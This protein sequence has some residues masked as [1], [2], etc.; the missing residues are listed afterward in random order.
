M[1]ENQQK[2]ENGGSGVKRP[3]IW[4]NMQLLMSCLPQS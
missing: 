4:T 2:P 1:Q 3:M